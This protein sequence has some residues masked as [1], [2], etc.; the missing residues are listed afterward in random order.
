MKRILLL[1]A[2]AVLFAPALE[3]FPSFQ[4]PTA[5]A[6]IEKYLA[7]MGGRDALGK[8][9][10]RR[11]T[12]TVVFNTQGNNFNGTYEVSAKAPNKV[13]VL[14]K[15]DLSAVGMT[16]P[17]TIDQRFDGSNGMTMSSM[18][19]NMAIGGSQLE[20]MKNNAFP[21]PLLNYKTNGMTFEVLPKEQVA[22]RDATV[23]VATPKVGPSMRLY[24]DPESGLLVRSVVRLNSPAQGEIEQTSE[25]SDYRAVD[26]VKV[27]FK[28]LNTSPNQTVTITITKV[29]HNVA[30][31]D[32]IFV[33]K[34]L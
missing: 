20:H 31:D 17:V 4:A 22:G 13:R 5:D 8:L 26:G 28:V 34:G 7:A 19:G 33:A 3:A 24:F 15:L 14:I 6:V 12:G 16:D 25:P 18:E 27:P 30:L 2:G 29:E 11:S 9:T 1:L 21:S 10:S 32:T 23:V